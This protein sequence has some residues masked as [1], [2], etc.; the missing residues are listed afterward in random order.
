MLSIEDRKSPSYMIG[1]FLPALICIFINSYGIITQSWSEYTHIISNTLLFFMF[2]NIG[3]R[4]IIIYK[5]KLIGY[6]CLFLFIVVIILNLLF[7]H[8]G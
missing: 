1:V 7:R 3:I 2:L 4:E 5:H 8:S 6:Y